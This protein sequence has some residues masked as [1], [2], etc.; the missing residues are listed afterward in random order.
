VAIKGVTIASPDDRADLTAP[1]EF[2]RE[3]LIAHRE[4]FNNRQHLLVYGGPCGCF[5]CL[6]LFEASAVGVWVGRGDATALCPHCHIDAVLPG[7]DVGFLT[8]MQQYFFHRSVRIRLDLRSK[9]PP[10]C[11]GRRGPGGATYY[12]P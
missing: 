6:R 10:M 9:K 5:Y 1:R 7:S 3:L 8:V 12:G 4:S 2:E 11:K